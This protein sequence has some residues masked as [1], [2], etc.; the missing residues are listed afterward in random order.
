MLLVGTPEE[1]EEI[2]SQALISIQM[3]IQT[4]FQILI[5]FLEDEY[6]PNVRPG[7]L[8]ILYYIIVKLQSERQ[9]LYY[10]MMVSIYLLNA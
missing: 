5:D 6:L 2:Q 4:G 10:E 3:S 9:K 1:Q 7:E 8:E